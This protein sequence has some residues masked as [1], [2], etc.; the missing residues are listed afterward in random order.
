MG[1]GTA[2]AGDTIGTF[3]FADYVESDTQIDLE[4]YAPYTHPALPVKIATQVTTT[5]RE[6]P[7][8]GDGL[9]DGVTST[10]QV[11]LDNVTAGLPDSCVGLL[12]Q[13]TTG[14]AANIGA[15][16]RITVHAA[17]RQMTVNRALPATPA[18]G[19]GYELL[20]DV[21]RLSN[22]CVKSEFSI[23]GATAD[24]IP[25]F[26][27]YERNLI[28]TAYAR[29][30]RFPAAQRTLENLAYQG[31]TEEASYF[32]GL[33]LVME[34]TVGA[35]GVKIRLVSITSGNVSLWAWAV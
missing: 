27:A 28:D 10:T 33:T 35:R 4:Q 26:R 3:T 1:K 11:Q 6:Y 34:P 16:R 22:L 32:N 14:T 19:D 9:L 21:F 23:S 31:Q 18:V 5:A 12:L 29:N 7:Y 25:V 8:D 24:V 17:N 13:M 2:V 30:V 15:V 20:V